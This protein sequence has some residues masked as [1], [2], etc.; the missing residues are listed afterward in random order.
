MAGFLGQFSEETAPNPSPFQQNMKLNVAVQTAQELN[1]ETSQLSV[2]GS[3]NLNVGGTLANPVILGRTSLTGGDIFFMG[4]RYVVQNG[5]IE[6]A[7]PVRTEPILNIFMNTTVQ[8]YN[9]T[10]N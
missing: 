7:N 4:K 3:A 10:L 8:Q 1:A 2:E 5:T 6:F 9:I